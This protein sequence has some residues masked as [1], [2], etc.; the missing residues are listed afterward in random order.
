MNAYPVRLVA[1]LALVALCALAKESPNAKIAELQTKPAMP[2]KIPPDEV[3]L[4][5]KP[6][7]LPTQ[8]VD[9]DEWRRHLKQV[10]Q[11]L[12]EAFQ[13]EALAA[14]HALY[15][16]ALTKN[17]EVAVFFPLEEGSHRAVALPVLRSSW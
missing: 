17:T 5:E 16:K 7:K 14:P 13:R 6:V 12:A 10:N 15:Q 3:G 11:E 2:R 9:V 4:N 8:V 1:G